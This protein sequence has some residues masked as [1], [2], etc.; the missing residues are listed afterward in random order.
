MRALISWSHHSKELECEWNGDD[1]IYVYDII[2]GLIW[3]TMLAL[4]VY[5]N[6]VGTC[7]IKLELKYEM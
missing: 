7:Y 1:M 3:Y 4:T 6:L 2:G 5:A